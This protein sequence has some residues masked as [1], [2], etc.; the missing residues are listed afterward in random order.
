MFWAVCTVH[1]HKT[2]IVIIIISF[3]L[4]SQAIRS[5][6][7]I[8]VS[9]EC[10]MVIGCGIHLNTVLHFTQLHSTIKT[11]H[12]C[13]RMWVLVREHELN[14]RASFKWNRIHRRLNFCIKQPREK[15]RIGVANTKCV[16]MWHKESCWISTINYNTHNLFSGQDFHCILSAQKNKCC[17]CD[18]SIVIIVDCV[19]LVRSNAFQFYCA[20]NAEKKLEW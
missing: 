7:N 8:D 5:Q 9:T 20:C 11:L 1:R 2:N 3:F 17:Y 15:R 18:C 13:E 10:V 14:G 6:Y 16:C 19:V 12:L 4:R